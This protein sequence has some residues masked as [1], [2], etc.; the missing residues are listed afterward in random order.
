MSMA[1]HLDHNRFKLTA[2]SFLRQTS[3]EKESEVN[4]RYILG[5]WQNFLIQQMEFRRGLLPALLCR[6][7][8]SLSPHFETLWTDRAEW[9]LCGIARRYGQSLLSLWGFGQ[10]TQQQIILLFSGETYDTSAHKYYQML[11]S[12]PILL[13][14]PLLHSV[15]VKQLLLYASNLA[16]FLPF[17]LVVLVICISYTYIPMTVICL[18]MVKS[19]NDKPNFH[20]SF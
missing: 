1:G 15:T 6:W 18:A 10:P 4:I 8:G 20:K 2:H 16:P 13:C 14:T 19:G 11:C 7:R 17:M 12:W 9:D 3:Y 5:P